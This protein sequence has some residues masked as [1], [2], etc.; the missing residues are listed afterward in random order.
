M[1]ENI[2][3]RY[4]LILSPVFYTVCCLKSFG[5]FVGKK[6][7]KGD[8]EKDITPRMETLSP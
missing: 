6:G 7:M 1:Y 5:L 4:N 2:S 8:R 3:V